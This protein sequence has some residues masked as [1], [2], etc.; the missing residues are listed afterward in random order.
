VAHYTGGAFLRHDDMDVKAREIKAYLKDEKREKEKKPG[1]SSLDKATA[2]G[3]V[4]IV[5]VTE[6]HTRR[7]T[8]EH[9]DY[10]ADESKI[11]LVGGKP[12]FEDSAKG[13][14]SGRELI[15]YSNDDRLLVNGAP[16]EPAVTKVRRKPNASSPNKRAK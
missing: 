12:V 4:V 15:Y 2:D 3:D 9:A 14:T 1:E 10:F 7:G 8:S 16:S 5:R 6:G 13:T 11:V